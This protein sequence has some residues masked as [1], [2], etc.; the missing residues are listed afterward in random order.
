M[1]AHHRAPLPREQTRPNHL[2]RRQ[3]NRQGAEGDRG[4]QG[5][6]GRVIPAVRDELRKIQK[7][8]EP[9]GFSGCRPSTDALAASVS[10]GV[11]AVLRSVA[12]PPSYMVGQAIPRSPK[13]RSSI[14]KSAALDPKMIQPSSRFSQAPEIQPVRLV[15]GVGFTNS[16]SSFTV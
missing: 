7:I 8:P 13:A 16:P 2:R 5:G 15:T 9:L 6:S 1:A 3:R 4:R 10:L 11:L 12:P 14:Q